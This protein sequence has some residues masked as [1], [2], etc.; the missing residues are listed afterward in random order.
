MANDNKKI[1]DLVPENDDDTSELEVLTATVVFDPDYDYQ[2]E[3]DAPTHSFETSARSAAG[4][5]ES[6]AALKSDLQKREENISNLQYDIE[7]LR[8]RWTGLEKELKARE[9]LTDNVTKE[10]EQSNRKLAQTISLLKKRDSKIT[11]L[12]SALEQQSARLA[13]AESAIENARQDAGSLQTEMEALEERNQTALNTIDSLNA[14]LIEEKSK[15]KWAEDAELAQGSRIEQLEQQYEESLSLVATLQQYVEGRKSSWERQEAAF[16]ASKRSLKEQRKE[17]SRL[18]REA[19]LT[20]ERLRK[21]QAARRNLQ[22]AR[23]SLQAE[24][25]KGRA[26]AAALMASLAEAE[27]SQ[28]TQYEQIASLAREIEVTAPA[29]EYEKAEHQ[30]LDAHLAEQQQQV[31]ALQ[32]ELSSLQQ[33]YNAKDLMLAEQQNSFDEMTLR[34][35]AT[36]EKL[37][38][39]ET[40]GEE[41]AKQLQLLQEEA[42]RLCRERNELLAEA[43]GNEQLITL[44]KQ[45]VVT[46]NRELE[47]TRARFES[48]RA[49]RQSTELQQEELQ[50]E[51]TRLRAELEPLRVASGKLAALEKANAELSGLVSSSEDGIRELRQRIA[52]TEAYAD[53]LR[54]KLQQEQSGVEVLS[55]KRD[56]AAISLAEALQRIDELTARLEAQ[57]QRSAALELENEEAARR[58]AEEVRKIRFELEAAEVTVAESQTLNEQLT[59]ELVESTELRRALERQLVDADAVRDR[60]IRDLSKQVAQL[61][62]QIDDYERK[63]SNKDAAINALLTELAHKPESAEEHAAAD[64]VVHRL[65]DRKSN[66]GDER[67]GH[68]EKDRVTRLLVG[69]IEGQELRFPLFKDKLTIGRTVH[70]DIQ[71]K[72][73]YVSRRHAVVVTEDDHTRIVDWGSKNGIYVNGKR[74]SEKM[75]KNGD[76]VTVGTAEFRF[77]ERPKR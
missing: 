38:T 72:A 68:H 64:D 25:E 62:Q 21:E 47:S 17:N 54:E 73:Q 2:S 50:H 29:L 39:E 27:E 12:E 67:A 14:D 52:K 49:L 44:Q 66:I 74:V 3:S 26:D 31:N 20:A 65:A 4:E 11:A 34:L 5:D 48:E 53:V 22:T 19:R 28:R 63:V 60:D 42:D 77:E 10:L 23:D 70:N 57:E 55:A 1:N 61:R 69:S 7:E 56:Q 71:L 37:V 8:T 15:R 35:I 13:E 9:V 18:A 51:A 6:I 32:A 45:D 40:S 58:L 33:A 24:L 75:L 59:A 30:R 16:N 36:T 46:L 76:R 41:L 43:A